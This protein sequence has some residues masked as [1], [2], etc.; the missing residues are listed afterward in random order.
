[1]APISKLLIS[2]LLASVA[3][4][5]PL[6][7][8][9]LAGE[10][11]AADSILTDTDNGVGY[12]TENAENNAASL[13]TSAKGSAPAPPH[14]RQLAGEGAAA[15]SILTDTDNGVGYGTENAENNAASLITSAKG[16]TPK[17]QLDKIANGAGNVCTAAGGDCGNQ[18]GAADSIDGAL[19]SGAAD[20]GAAVGS[21]EEQSLEAAGS[22]VPS[23]VPKR[24][25]DKIAN[26]AGNVCTAA[27]GDCGQQVGAADSIDGATT[28]GAANTGAAVGSTEEQS[29]EAAGSAVPSKVPK[30]LKN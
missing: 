27:G 15:D 6:A 23:K 8:R 21:T 12:G 7:R 3:I 26:G 30:M 22:A 10:G 16:S 24:Q 29:L 2:C 14:R 20:A 17:R 11:A 13:I 25:L 5:A 4:T 18:V 1:M 9:Q 28:S 19:T